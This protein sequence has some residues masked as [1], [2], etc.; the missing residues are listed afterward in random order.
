MIKEEN[1]ALSEAQGLLEQLRINL[2]GKNGY[3]WLEALKKFNRQEIPTWS[4]PTDW[5]IWKT[6]ANG[7]FKSADHAIF[8]LKADGIEVCRHLE[9]I[10]RK[11]HFLRFKAYAVDIVMV[12]IIDLGFHEDAEVSY[13]EIIKAGKKMDLRECTPY[14]VFTIRIGYTDQPVR[15]RVDENYL[16][17]MRSIN[18]RVFDMTNDSVS[19]GIDTISPHPVLKFNKHAKFFFRLTSKK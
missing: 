19:K 1:P 10:I 15:T 8:A 7:T 2:A 14:D 5:K 11:L 12:S 4:M 18:G 17:A 6:I 3:V 16:L 9:K 13:E